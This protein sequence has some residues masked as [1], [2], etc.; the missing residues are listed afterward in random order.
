M[1]KK[2]ITF[3]IIAIMAFSV[4][5]NAEEIA[6]VEET[7]TV[8]AETRENLALGKSVILYSD[9]QEA[10]PAQNLT[11]GD[12]I[13]YWGAFNK[14]NYVVID[15]EDVYYIDSLEFKPES[16]RAY[17]YKIEGSYDGVA[18]TEIITKENNASSELLSCEFTP[19]QARY[20]RFTITQLP[21]EVK[22]VN[23]KEIF[24]YG[25]SSGPDLLYNE[26]PLTIEVDGEI[27][28][29]SLKTGVTV[30][31]GKAV[32]LIIA[33]YDGNRM[34]GYKAATHLLPYSSEVERNIEI[35]EDDIGVNLN[36]KT[37]E[38]FV[39]DD[40]ENMKTIVAPLVITIDVTE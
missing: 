1:F 8:E 14:E 15:L 6:E 25:E 4:C 7:A 16:G 21:G 26:E 36:G 31:N 5:A 23:I 2:T 28:I 38:V 12:L 30:L 24:I 11:D 39:W 18:F 22:W 3:L 20:V 40:L 27:V 19:A 13:T 37:V 9:E 29:G 32:T 35:S 17:G 10:N 33:V 34:V